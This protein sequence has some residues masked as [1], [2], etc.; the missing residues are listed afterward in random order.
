MLKAQFRRD[1][2]K[3]NSRRS[4]YENEDSRRLPFYSA[5]HYKRAS[6]FLSL[7]V[8]LPAGNQ[9]DDV[10]N[11][12]AE[13]EQVEAWMKLRYTTL[14]RPVTAVKP[15]FDPNDICIKDWWKELE[16]AEKLL[17]KLSKD[18]RKSAHENE[19]A[20]ITT[21]SF[22]NYFK[23]VKGS[24]TGD[25]WMLMCN[26]GLAKNYAPLAADWYRFLER[27]TL[28]WQARLKLLLPDNISRR[29]LLHRMDLRKEFYRSLRNF[30]DKLKDADMQHAKKAIQAWRKIREEDSLVPL[31]SETEQSPRVE[32]VPNRAEHDRF[33]SEPSLDGSSDSTPSTST[34]GH[35][36]TSH[37]PSSST[38]RPPCRSGGGRSGRDSRRLSK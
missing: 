9:G 11:D 17:A 34:S 12:E 18:G 2:E 8:G 35:L 20:V 19:V 26:T 33:S 15:V 14:E 28:Y 30:F 27:L 21:D 38:S 25:L 1:K 22:M 36:G 4:N 24:P 16:K 31:S 7:V 23:N 3:A 6:L 37:G 29:Q 5:I 13:F 10:Q 32:A